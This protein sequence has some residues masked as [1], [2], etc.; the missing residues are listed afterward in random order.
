M[1]T[2]DGADRVEKWGVGIL[3]TSLMRSWMMTF[4]G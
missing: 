4:C 1:S 3:E 2:D